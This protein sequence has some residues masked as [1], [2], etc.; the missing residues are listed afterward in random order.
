[1]TTRMNGDVEGC[2]R[3]EMREVKHE[4]RELMRNPPNSEV[5]SPIS[6]DRL[7][8]GLVTGFCPGQIVRPLSSILQG[9]SG[10][11]EA[12]DGAAEIGMVGIVT[13][14]ILLSNVV[15]PLT[16]ILLF[17]L[18]CVF[19]NLDRFPDL[20]Y[21]GV[22]GKNIVDDIT[23]PAVPSSLLFPSETLS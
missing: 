11:R 3:V 4:V 5:A 2:I 8:I 23:P 12:S 22:I 6:L 20:L 7:R 13:S 9:P 10:S 18:S 15:D 16:T 21:G 14:F 17:M 1:M 19:V